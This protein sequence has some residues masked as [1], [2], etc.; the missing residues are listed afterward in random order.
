[1]GETLRRR[2]GDWLGEADRSDQLT[3]LRAEREHLDPETREAMTQA[4]DW[5]S[6]GARPAHGG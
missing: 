1:M 2:L 3:A 6:A 5:I 4:A